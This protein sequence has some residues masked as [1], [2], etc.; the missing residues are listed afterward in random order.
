[1]RWERLFADLEAQFDAE[2]QAGLEADRADLVRSERGQ[3]LLADRLR[4][5]RGAVLG[6]RLHPDAAI[7]GA[8]TAT[9]ADL[10]SDWLLLAPGHR[11]DSVQR[12]LLVPMRIVLSVAGLSSDAL[13]DN[14]EIAKR[15]GLTVVLRGLARDRAPVQLRTAA[16][17]LT[18]T[19]DRVGRDHLDL[20]VHDLDL[21]RRAGHVREVRCVPLAAVA[22]IAVRDAPSD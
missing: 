7:G 5:H 19:I 18:G 17:P 15:M 8:L 6:W 3:V 12:H 1:M 20:A 16:E 22:L 2:D 14:S 4:A 10:G 21:P 11:S 9:L 13:L